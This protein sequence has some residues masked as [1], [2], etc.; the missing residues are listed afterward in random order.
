MQRPADIEGSCPFLIYEGPCPYGLACRFAGTHRDDVSAPTENLP[1][2]SSELNFFNKDTQKLLWKNK[3]KFPETE[4]T[5]KLLGL[6]VCAA[7]HFFFRSSIS[8]L[9]EQRCHFI[10]QTSTFSLMDKMFKH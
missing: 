1:V 10:R 8:N 9:G 6:K 5:L 3:M 7:H 4:S 2:K